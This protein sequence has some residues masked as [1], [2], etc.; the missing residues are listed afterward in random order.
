MEN[1][2]NMDKMA[3]QKKNMRLM[4]VGFLVILAGNILLMGGGSDDPAVFNRA[5][6]DFQ[7]L[8]AAPIIL[9]CG[10]IVEIVAIVMITKNK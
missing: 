1:K 2:E 8:V 10:V 3:L 7:R 6:F 5:M 4:L 9:I